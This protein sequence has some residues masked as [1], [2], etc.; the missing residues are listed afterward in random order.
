M[1]FISSRIARQ[2]QFLP[3]D[4]VVA[5][6]KSIS[7]LA[8]AMLSFNQ[9]NTLYPRTMPLSEEI[10]RLLKWEPPLV[11]AACCLPSAFIVGL[12]SAWAC[13]KQ[14]E[15][16]KL[17]DWFQPCSC[18][19][20]KSIPSWLASCWLLLFVVMFVYCAL[21]AYLSRAAY[22]ALKGRYTK[23]ILNCSEAVRLQ[24]YSVRT[25]LYR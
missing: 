17:C 14:A 7:S 10:Q 6:L 12:L 5:E 1:A 2:L 11:D 15:R 25:Y 18:Y 19:W 24:P 21:K 4:S 20:S 16:Q 9:M 22:Y 3:D 8:S 23:A 13:Q